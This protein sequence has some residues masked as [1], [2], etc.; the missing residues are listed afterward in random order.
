MT[1]AKIQEIRDKAR[2][3]H[4]LEDGWAGGSGFAF[5]LKQ[6]DVGFLFAKKRDAE[7][8]ASKAR[9]LV[10]P[11]QTPETI[12]WSRPSAAEVKVAVKRFFRRVCKQQQ[13]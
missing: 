2:D 6:R 5:P 3:L 12:V 1:Q 8:F 9:A 7:V 11:E 10:V 13:P 4:L